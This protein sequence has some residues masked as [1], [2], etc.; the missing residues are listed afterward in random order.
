MSKDINTLRKVN[1]ASYPQQGNSYFGRTRMIREHLQN[2]ISECIISQNKSQVTGWVR[3]RDKGANERMGE[4]GVRS[5][6]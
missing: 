2:T 4:I 1:V 5:S 3:E 6:G